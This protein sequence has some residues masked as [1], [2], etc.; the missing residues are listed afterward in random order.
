MMKEKRL[1]QDGRNEGRGGVFIG[2]PKSG[3]RLCNQISLLLVVKH[4]GT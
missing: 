1:L 3:N 2:N 4:P